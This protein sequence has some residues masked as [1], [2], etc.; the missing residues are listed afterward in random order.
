MI[1]HLLA[2]QALTISRMITTKY[3]K[4]INDNDT[5]IPDK[6][7]MSQ[8]I[9]TN[10]SLADT[11][12]SLSHEAPYYPPLYEPLSDVFYGLLLAVI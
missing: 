3:M 2:I 7:L 10:Q 8:I 1:H 4:L 12:N 5:P 9:D 11:P 6:A